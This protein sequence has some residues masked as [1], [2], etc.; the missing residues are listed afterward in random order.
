M[1]LFF[2]GGEIPGWRELMAREGVKDVSLSFV[3]LH[4][5][6]KN[7]AK[8]FSIAD[9]FPGDM[10]VFLDSGAYSFNK[11]NSGHTREEA[12][13]LGEAYK[14]FVEANL[15]RVEMVSEFDVLRFGSGT[16]EHN[17]ENFY[18][19][20][21]DKF[22]PIWHQE[23]GIDELE[24]LASAYRRVG[25]TETEVENRDITP[26]LNNLVGRYGVLLHGVA[27]T[28]MGS[29]GRVKW[30]SVGSTSWLSPSQYGDTFVWT[31]TELKRY[32]MKY[33]DQARRRHRTLF[34][35]NGFDAQ[36]I[37]DDNRDE[38]LRLSLWSWTQFLADINRHRAFSSPVV[39][40]Q[41][42]IPDDD[43]GEEDDGVVV[44]LH[45]ETGNAQLVTQGQEKRST[46]DIP[47]LSTTWNTTEN[48]DGSST[49]T[50]MFGVSSESMRMC[51]TCFL[52][53]KCP[54]FTPGASCAYK[55]PVEV[56][57]AE[58][59]RALQEGL[60]E[61]QAQRVTFA[62]MTEQ[63][64]G[65][66]PDPNLSS[67]ID[68]LGR[69]IKQKQDSEKEIFKASQDITM[70]GGPGFISKMFGPA[71]GEKLH[72]ATAPPREAEKITGIIGEVLKDDD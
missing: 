49:S 51:D 67:E 54:A 46:V 58:Q 8:N 7:G 43:N 57:T 24:R 40:Q 25:I 55:I 27:I 53:G 31:G 4:R 3:G 20:L 29:M 14:D 30:D 26:V 66:Y 2:G 10:N 50:P 9:N 69:L 19:L 36:L 33:K 45:P 56:K 12:H 60:I 35:S 6:T 61:M 41:P 65:G 17:R 22:M 16:M 48:E 11:E 38:I 63:I 18:D 34:E 42:E 5:R 64:E 37:A 70:S 62:A 32:P 28:G 68:R 71:A 21:G 52:K 13:Q 1:R 72:D 39:T 47:L 15:D 23:Y 59:L 44:H